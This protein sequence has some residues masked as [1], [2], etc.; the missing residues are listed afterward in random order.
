LKLQKITPEVG[1]YTVKYEAIDAHVPGID[2]AKQEEKDMMGGITKPEELDGDN[3][4]LHPRQISV[5]IQGV[6][7]NK[8]IGR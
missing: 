5:H 6:D 7:F 3:L 1:E 4:I 8:V 2:L